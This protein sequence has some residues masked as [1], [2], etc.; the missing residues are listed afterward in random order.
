[1]EN[2]IWEEASNPAVITPKNRRAHYIYM[3]S[4]HPAHLANTVSKEEENH[5]RPSYNKRK[6][7]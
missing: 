6:E 1:M 7:K 4:E 5:Y 2:C 3:N